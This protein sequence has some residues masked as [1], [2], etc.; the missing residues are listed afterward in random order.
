MLEAE[1]Y[2]SPAHG[3]ALDWFYSLGVT[4]QEFICLRCAM[5]DNADNRYMLSL[6]YKYYLPFLERSVYVSPY[7]RWRNWQGK[8]G[9]FVNETLFYGNEYNRIVSNGLA[10]G[11][12]VGAH[13]SEKGRFDFTIY[14]GGG[15]YFYESYKPQDGQTI[16]NYLISEWR[17]GINIGFRICKAKPKP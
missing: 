4:G 7:M 8:L 11:G 9:D 12:T 3:L 2:F 10:F 1:Y 13:F 5:T 6:N 15:K 16:D 17:L 14:M